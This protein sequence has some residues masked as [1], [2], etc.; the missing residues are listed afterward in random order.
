MAGK[1][2]L[3]DN[4]L[5]RRQ[6]VRDARQIRTEAIK[7]ADNDL[8]EAGGML[9][10]GEF[11]HSR[12]Y[13]ITS[14]Q[15][16]MKSS[17]NSGSTRVFQALPRKLRRRT[18]S[19]NV[20]H[21][22]KRMRNRALREMRKSNVADI[23]NKGN[24]LQKK[25]KYRNHGLS[26]RQLYKMRMAVKLLRLATRSTALRLALPKS[27]T[28][29]N[30][31]IRNKIKTL[32][33]NIKAISKGRTTANTLNNAMGSYDVVSV[34][35]L[36][37]LP[38]NRIKYLKRQKLFTWL[39]THV[40][41]AKRSHMM[42]RWGYQIA[43]APTQKC[44][45]LTHRLGSQ[46]AASD[47]AL[48]MDT[49]FY[50]TMLITL[51][52]GV[53]TQI[54]NDIIGI[55][56]NNKGNK[57]KYKNKILWFEGNMYYPSNETKNILGPLE[58]LW[59][60]ERKVMIR[61]H[62]A[63]YGKV[64]DLLQKLYNEKIDIT[65][66][67]FALSSFTI[68]GAAALSSLLSILRSTEKSDS[69]KQLLGIAKVADYSMLPKNTIF[70]FMALDPRYLT[71]PHIPNVS[72]NTK[73]LMDNILNIQNNRPEKEL[74]NIID[75]LT[76]SDS[77]TKSY[78]NQHTLKMIAKRRR[79]ELDADRKYAGTSR[80]LEFNKKNDPEIPLLLIKRNK[81]N[82]WLA[83]LPWFWMLPFWYQLNKL[84]RVY[85]IGLRQ[86]QQ[87]QY[88]HNQFYFPDDFPF[89]EIGYLESKI[90][91]RGS[92]Y[93]H[94][95]KKPL[96]KRVN[97][98]KIKNIHNTILPAF[99]G[100]IGDPFCSD[101]RFLQILRNG[102]WYLKKENNEIRL[103]D[104]AKTGQFDEEKNRLVGN[105]NDLLELYKDLTDDQ[106][107]EET[108]AM[109]PVKL[110]SN[111]KSINVASNRPDTVSEISTKQLNITPVSCVCKEKGRPKDNARI[112]RIPETHMK[113]WISVAQG[114]YLANGKKLHDQ[115]APRPEIHDLIGFATSGSY[116]LGKG[117]GTFT[118]FIDSD[119]IGNKPTQYIL[120][121]N[122]GTTIYRLA[123]WSQA[124]I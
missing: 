11:I 16:A 67:R 110:C 107:Q 101:W 87:L 90:Y 62:P 89:T 65:D 25:S 29:K 106:I 54:L 9:N 57:E 61:L 30:T 92:M 85:H 80:V 60:N 35:E 12:R 8:S 47:G 28:L 70:G 76:D 33:R 18:A 94:W 49:S 4:Q 48:C 37:P 2:Q 21:I 63:L 119:Y 59:I 91:K 64:F 23:N 77:R 19:H 27:V 117:M 109:I 40:W 100:E 84:P 55:I 43:W 41:N 42:K 104:P 52:A 22:P 66:A 93:S 39:P 123:E 46:T 73:N 36:A 56:T 78:Y 79:I 95:K 58:L 105:M 98:E 97:Y 15:L 113:Y 121:R 38:K 71:T 81:S 13:E 69:Y 83:I 86:V 72:T 82:D 44:F 7:Q 99:E 111:L 116:N 5:F 17:K 118:G 51:Q 102:I 124:N 96:G 74:S 34:N 112:Y 32:K 3:N 50:G 75:R 45:K 115:E 1:K 10:V 6:K 26:K 53:E 24:E 31:R 68:R 120:W 103:I 14:L 88:E 114:K 122:P 108:S 20:K